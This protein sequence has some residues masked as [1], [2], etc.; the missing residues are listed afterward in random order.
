M[1]CICIF[2]GW[3]VH[4]TL[5]TTT[6]HYTDYYRDT[7]TCSERSVAGITAVQK[8]RVHHFSCGF[9][10]EYD[11]VHTFFGERDSV[12]SQEHNPQHIAN[13]RV[14]VHHYDQH[15]YMEAKIGC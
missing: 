4:F 8:K 2:L 11:V 13:V 7:L 12:V 14:I 5:L 9:N 6:D 1:Y 10:L 3:K 15:H